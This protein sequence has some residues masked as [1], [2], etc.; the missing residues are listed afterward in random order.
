MSP[1]SLFSPNGVGQYIIQ[2]TDPCN[3]APSLGPVRAGAQLRIPARRHDLP[4][5]SAEHHHGHGQRALRP[6][7]GRRCRS[8]PCRVRKTF[9]KIPLP[10]NKY[11]NVCDIHMIRYSRYGTG[12][13]QAV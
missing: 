13:C 9:L 8:L 12:T 1:F 7:L 11:S 10:K 3:T 4:Q 5:L 2:Y 6:R